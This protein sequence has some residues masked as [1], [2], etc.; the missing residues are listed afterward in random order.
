MDV[1]G[2][3]RR[4]GPAGVAGGAV[5]LLFTYGSLTIGEE[6]RLTYDTPIVTAVVLG[7]TVASLLSG[8]AVA[9]VL[10]NEDSS[11]GTLQGAWAGAVAGL[12]LVVYLSIQELIESEVTRQT[13]AT[14]TLVQI[15]SAIVGVAGVSVSMLV[16]GMIGGYIGHQIRYRGDSS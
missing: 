5:L 10:G 7:V 15:V 8:G 13:T 11:L 6:L 16:P 1:R 2:Q 14:D 9:V 3:L 4:Y 12:L